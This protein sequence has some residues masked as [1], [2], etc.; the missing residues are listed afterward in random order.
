MHVLGKARVR[1]LSIVKLLSLRLKIKYKKTYFMSPVILIYVWLQRNQNSLSPGKELSLDIRRPPT[2]ES[3]R[4]PTYVGGSGVGI[5]LG[6]FRLTLLV[7]NT[8]DFTK[9]GSFERKFSLLFDQRKLK[10]ILLSAKTKCHTYNSLVLD[11]RL[12]VTDFGTVLFFLELLAF[13]A[14]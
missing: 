9:E 3:I 4:G 14:T 7:H 1:F 2:Q 11:L 5:S 8:S 13:L 12:T 6:L 10:A